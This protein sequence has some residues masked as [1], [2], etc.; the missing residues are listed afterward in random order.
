MLPPLLRVLPLLYRRYRHSSALHSTRTFA[1]AAPLED[2]Q[3]TLDAAGL[4]GA[5]LA[6]RWQE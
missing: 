5:M 2:L 3:Q 4:H 6:L 1:G